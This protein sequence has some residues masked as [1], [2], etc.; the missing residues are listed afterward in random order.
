[1]SGGEYTVS[2][3]LRIFCSSLPSLFCRAR[4]CRGWSS[5]ARGQAEQP[6]R[7]RFLQAQSGRRYQRAEV[8]VTGQGGPG[9]GRLPGFW[10][11]SG[12]ERREPGGVVYGATSA[13]MLPIVAPPDTGIDAAHQGPVS[14]GRTTTRPGETPSLEPILLKFFFLLSGM[15]GQRRCID[16]GG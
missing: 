15:V 3:L 12:P 10:P 5:W 8:N 2:R 6:H 1:M 13:E 7:P 9:G 14:L 4:F 11:G 16:R